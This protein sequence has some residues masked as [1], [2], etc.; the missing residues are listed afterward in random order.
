MF[1]SGKFKNSVSSNRSLLEVL[2]VCTYTSFDRAGL[3]DVKGPSEKTFIY[4]YRIGI[5]LKKY[6]A[7]IFLA[8]RVH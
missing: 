8:L 2:I 4:R 3:R 7:I 6:C 5:G 1:Y